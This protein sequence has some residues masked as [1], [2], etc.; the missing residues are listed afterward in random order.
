MELEFYNQTVADVQFNA[1]VV[2]DALF[3][4]LVED[5]VMTKE[6]TEKYVVVVH[7]KGLFGRVLESLWDS[8]D[9]VSFKVLR[10]K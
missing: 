2:K 1:N 8:S 10:L 7:K 4:V 6:Q 5:G 9:K 3:Q